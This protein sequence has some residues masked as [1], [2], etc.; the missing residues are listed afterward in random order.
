[1]LLLVGLLFRLN[2]DRRAPEIGLL[3]ATGL[4]RGFVRRLLLA[5]GALLAAVG[6]IVGLV[7]AVGYAWLL[8]RFLTATWPG[9][10]GESGLHSFL[11]L[12]V[13][14]LSLLIGFAS[15]FVV[16]L[17]TIV[18]ATRVLGRV[19]PRA[20]LAGETTV[21]ESGGERQQSGW[22]VG[23]MVAGL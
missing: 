21:S 10:A 7:G 8:L 3:L 13:T 9:S 14:S 2:L 18:W 16:S 11:H 20:L 12:Q 19:A 23:I 6:G 15:A 22:G 4:R 1:A 17:L 5:E